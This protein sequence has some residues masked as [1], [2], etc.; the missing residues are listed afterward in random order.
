MIGNF[1]Y[2]VFLFFSRNKT[3]FLFTVT[4]LFGFAGYFASR[5][6]FEEDISR[7]IPSDEKTNRANFILK[8][9][10][11]ADRLVLNISLA[12]SLAEAN[13]DLLTSY[14]ENLV[15]VLDS[16]WKPSHISEITATVPEDLMLTVNSIFYS[17]LPLFLEENDYAKIDSMLFPKKVDE[18]MQKNYNTLISPTGSFLKQ[19]I[20]RDPLGL[21]YI[22]LNRLQTL[23]FNSNYETYNGYLFSSDMKHLIVFLTLAHPANETSENGILIAGIEKLCDSLSQKNPEVVTEYFGGAAMAVANAGRI[24]KDITLTVTIATVVL[25]LV[26]SVFFRRKLIFLAIMLPVVFGG[27]AALAL[28]FLVKAKVSAVALGVG[29]ILM[30]ITIDFSLHIFTHYRH[31]RSAERVIKDVAQPMLMSAFTTVAAFLCLQFANSEVLRDLGLFAAFSIFSSA[32]FALLVL[33]QLLHFFDRKNES[34]QQNETLIDKFCSY[35]FHKNKILV[36]AVAVFTVVAFFC[37]GEIQFEGDMTRMNY[38]PQKLQRAEENLNRINNYSLKSVF[39]VSS[40]KTMEEALKAEENNRSKLDSLLK[41][42]IVKK[43]ANPGLLLMSESLQEQKLKRWKNFWTA[44]KKEALRKNISESSAKYKFSARAFEQFSSQLEKDFQPLS[45]AETDTLKKLFLRDYLT[46]TPELTA[47]T[48]LLSVDENDKAKAY[49]AFESENKTDILDKK[50]LTDR[51]IEIIKTDFNTIL[52]LSSALVFITFLISYGRIELTLLTFIPM[53]ISWIWIL[54]IMSVFGIKFNII[55]IIISTFIFG[56]GD[57]YSI[58]TMNGMLEEYRTGRKNLSSYKTSIFLSAFTTIIGIGV[59]IFAEHPALKS[60]AAVAITGMISVVIISFVIQPLLFDWLIGSRRER[61]IYPLTL[62]NIIKTIVVWTTLMTCVLILILLGPIVYALFFLPMK[63]RK[64]IYQWFFCKVSTVFIYITFPGKFKLNNPQNEDFK[65][66]AIIICNHMSLIETPMV[67]MLYPKLIFLTNKWVL[68]TPHFGPIAY[69]ADFFDVED[70][71]DEVMKQLR[72]KMND[73]YSLVI[74]PE[75]TR[76]YDF[77]IHRYHRGAFYMAEQMQVDIIPVLFQGT[78]E[79]LR[80][81]SIFGKANTVSTN[82]LPRIKPGDERFG[83]GHRERAKKITEY[84]REQYALIR[85]REEPP[86]YYRKKIIENYIYK[87]PVLEWY[88]RVK[89]RLED[90]YKMFNEL[91][92]EKAVVTDIGCGYG[93][94]SY[95]LFYTSEDRRIT[96]IDYDEEKIEVAN[97]CFAKTDRINFVSGDASAMN[98]EQ[99]DVFILADM[100]HYLTPEKQNQLLENC[101]AALNG[102]GMIIIRDGDRDLQERHKG[103]KLTE[104]FSTKIIGFNKT[105]NQLHFISRSEVEAFA[106]KHNLKAEVIDNTKLTS[107]IVMVLRKGHVL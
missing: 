15:A 30:G 98:F 48:T 81:H 82:I 3:V 80:K 34:T 36:A 32:L 106:A 91:V 62:K 16:A 76:S 59:L 17:N 61:G 94:L 26:I 29:S 20:A 67:K 28:L 49:A 42:D 78:G 21:T 4:M 79:F 6:K 70:G 39:L 11:F 25:M 103:T 73:G 14:A 12:D 52:L 72:E 68:K 19:N 7:M 65:K 40:G 83:S 18:A 90:D 95:M 64:A 89:I 53:A 58:F 46:E 71:S 5:L 60:I 50:F 63:K 105:E 23:Q 57:D 22:A 104:L 44:E 8:N 54:G 41:L 97:N 88:L 87:G 92:P 101:V 56:L 10:K 24:K 27:I 31:V 43:A 99:S 35:P 100:L 86:A 66:P 13:P 74:F 102:N 84:V 37:I 47:V 51:F 2:S 1:F 9:S 75:G 77:K 69:M 96:G 55:N 45:K 38:V 93:F 85:K 107:N 33:P